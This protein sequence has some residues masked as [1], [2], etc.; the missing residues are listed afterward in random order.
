MKLLGASFS[1]YRPRSMKSSVFKYHF[2]R[3]LL[4]LKKQHIEKENTFSFCMCIFS[5]ILRKKYSIGNNF[6]R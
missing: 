4:A 3:A 1:Y 5:Y 2:Y 6:E